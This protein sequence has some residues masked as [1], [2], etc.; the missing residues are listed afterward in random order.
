MLH[1]MI[2]FYV[3]LQAY[4]IKDERL[5]V[6]LEALLENV[7]QRENIISGVTDR[8][9]IEL[10]VL[11]EFLDNV[12]RRRPKGTY[13]SCELSCFC[14]LCKIFTKYQLR[15]EKCSKPFNN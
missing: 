13:F 6:E 5:V 2:R 12:A 4:A 11:S 10:G 14:I 8:L 1:K 15:S 7:A 9:Q 3:I